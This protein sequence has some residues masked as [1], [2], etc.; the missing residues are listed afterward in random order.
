M[1]TAVLVAALAAKLA[2]PAM[3]AEPQ[4]GA[5]TCRTVTKR[6][7]HAGGR[8]A[9]VCV[10]GFHGTAVG[11]VLS[12]NGTVVCELAGEYDFATGCLRITHL[13]TGE[14]EVACR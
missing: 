7:L 2:G 8:H 4:P 3:Q 9:F 5:L 6:E 14:V 10:E 13:C 11:A 12:K 1:T